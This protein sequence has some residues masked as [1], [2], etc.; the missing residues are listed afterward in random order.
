MNRNSGWASVA[1]VGRMPDPRELNLLIEATEA[2][3]RDNVQ[4]AE[5][6]AVR[7]KLPSKMRRSSQYVR[8][9]SEFELLWDEAQ[10]RPIDI[11]IRIVRDSELRSIANDCLEVGLVG[12][13][14]LA[15][16]LLRAMHTSLSSRDVFALLRGWQ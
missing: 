9:I 16:M 14:A 7:R 2:A 8:Q 1:V 5:G 10:A 6:E 3:P 13:M 12:A 15:E 4:A 11:S